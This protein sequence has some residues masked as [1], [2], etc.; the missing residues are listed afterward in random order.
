M[1]FCFRHIRSDTPQRDAIQRGSQMP[2]HKEPGERSV[3]ANE[4]KTVAK[5]LENAF[6]R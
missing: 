1:F 4:A 2:A 5:A 3:T 6:R